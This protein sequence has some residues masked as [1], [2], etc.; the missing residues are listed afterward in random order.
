MEEF[1][2]TVVLLAFIVFFATGMGVKAARDTEMSMK[3]QI[4]DEKRAEWVADEK[5]QVH[6]K[7]IEAK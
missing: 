6:F 5:G 1:F 7:W 2:C 3:Q 4:V